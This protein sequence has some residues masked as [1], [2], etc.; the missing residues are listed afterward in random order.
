MEKIIEIL[1]NTRKGPVT[2]IL[3]CFFVVFGSWMIYENFTS[4]EPKELS[5]TS[6]ETGVMVIGLILLVSPDYKQKRDG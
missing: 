1:G 6:V 3:G 4:L 2:T 5:W